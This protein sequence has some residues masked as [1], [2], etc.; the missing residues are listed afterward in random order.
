M[1][2]LAYGEIL[3]DIIEGTEHLGGA[4]FNFAAHSVKCGN[5]SY[6]IS[7][8]GGDF[9][10]MRA[11]NQCNA[12]G[13]HIDFIQWDDTYP[14]G[15]VDVTLENGQPNYFIHEKVAYDFIETGTV[16]RALEHIAFDFFYFGS[17]AQRSEVSA[18]TLQAILSQHKFKN[19]FYDVNLRKSGYSEAIIRNSLKVCTIFKLNADE[20]SVISELLIGEILSKDKFCEMITGLFANVKI[21]IITAAE[22]GCFVFE[23]RVTHFIQGIPVA[24]VDAVGAGDAF[25]AAFIH[26]FVKTGNAMYAAQIANHVGAYVASKR[27]AI[28]EYSQNINDLLNCN[29]KRFSNATENIL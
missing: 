18:A 24:V 3:W 9:L 19:I 7:R 13:V 6:I 10:G 28:P 22:K 20:L 16:V 15:S 17:L 27:G 12:H 25:S 23:N 21:I 8:L 5:E 2:V 29:E 14:T 4:P 11:F 26:N 1:K